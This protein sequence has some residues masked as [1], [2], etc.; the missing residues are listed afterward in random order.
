MKRRYIFA[1]LFLNLL[2]G[3]STPKYQICDFFTD[4]EIQILSDTITRPSI[5][6]SLD[7]L[8]LVIISY[9]MEYNAEKNRRMRKQL[10]SKIDYNTIMFDSLEKYR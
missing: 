4:Y 6:K 8:R 10:Q 2:Y 5:Q 9:Q 3:C 7:S 1:I